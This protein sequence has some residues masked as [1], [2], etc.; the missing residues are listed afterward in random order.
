VSDAKITRLEFLKILFWGSTGVM[1]GSLGFFRIGN[2]GKYKQSAF[3]DNNNRGVGG[4]VDA[5][6]T[7]PMTE[8]ERR[9]RGFEI[10]KKA[11]DMTYGVEW[12]K[13]PNN[14]EEND[15]R[16]NGEPTYI[17]NYSKGLPHNKRGEPDR[18][19]YRSLLRALESGDPKDFEN[20]EVGN[21]IPNGLRFFNPQAGLTF[22]L[23]GPDPFGLFQPPAPRIDSAEG[24]AEMAELYWMSLVRD[25]NFTNF[26]DNKLIERAAE[27]LSTYADFHGPKENGKVTPD[28]IFR[29]NWPG[30][31]K[32]P[33]VSQFAWELRFQLLI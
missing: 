5:S 4:R 8:S 22:T 1:L 29:G 14:G 31:L 32:G 28:T 3:A 19:A 27:D 12:P 13:H 10:R 18:E 25:V 15:Y 23:E 21:P 2:D 20:I 16:E 7:F 24:A 9:A 26:D 17:A 30:T 33:Y 6:K 11:A